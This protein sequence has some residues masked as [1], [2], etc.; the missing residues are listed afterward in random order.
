MQLLQRLR[1]PVS[2]TPG[3]NESGMEVFFPTAGQ[4][5]KY[6]WPVQRLKHLEFLIFSQFNSSTVEPRF[7]E[8]PRDWGNLFVTPRVRYISCLKLC[9]R[10]A[11]GTVM[12]FT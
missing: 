7:N 10:Q 9:R 1:V 2:L 6:Y 4:T 11:A 8:V 12:T 3:A 5:G